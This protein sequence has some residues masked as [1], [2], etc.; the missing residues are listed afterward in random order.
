[1]IDLKKVREQLDMYKQDCMKKGSRIDVDAILSLDEERKTL[2]QQ[3]DALKN[4][5]K[6]LAA[7]QDY[8]GAKALK[9]EIQSLDEHY[10][11]L[12][13]RLNADLLTMPGFI[14]PKVPT[15]KDES[16]N[17][18][19][20]TVGETPAFDFE[21]QDHIT[22]M[23][24]HDMVDIERGVK[25]AGARSYFLKNDGMLL[26][27][28]VLQYALSKMVKKGFSPMQV[29]NMVNPE[30]LVGTGYFPGGEEDAYWLERDNQWLIATAEIPLTS[31]HSGELLTEAELPKKY[32]GLSPCYRREAGSYG[33]DTSGLYRVH[34]FMKVEQ[35]VIIPEDVK[36]SDQYHAQIL[37]NSEELV[38]DLGLPYRILQLCS[39]DLA[40]G[41]YDSHDIE[42]WMPSRNSYGETHSA[43]SF[44]DF[45]SRRLNLRYRAEDGS[46]K[47]AYT[48]NN[49]VAA[50]PRLLIAIIENNQ[51]A[52]GKIRIPEVLQPYMG[53][54][55]IG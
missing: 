20:K 7:Q 47:Y 9:T 19:I 40:L 16:E 41:K 30:A 46:I 37:A 55:V 33:K 8:E 1:M 52:D 36:M 25:L 42:C 15:G 22:L 39:G 49:T 48:L 18:I 17:V 43:T 6:Q 2:Q 26:E 54:E 51:T 29:P 38:A 21:V 10:S 44:L 27:Q 12:L 35:V 28:A 31:Y 4:Q 14:S 23:K 32:V 13:I 34:Q 24:K 45:Q 53:K 5:Q 50:T 11:E 3:I